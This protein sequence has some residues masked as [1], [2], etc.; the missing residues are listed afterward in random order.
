MDL[1]S[2][3]FNL[4]IKPFENFVETGAKAVAQGISGPF[5]MA[6]GIYVLFMGWRFISGQVEEPILDTVKRFLKIVI[7]AGVAIQLT[8]YNVFFR[9]FFL[10]GPEE[11]ARWL[12]PSATG[13]TTQLNIL[14]SVFTEMWV[15][16]DAFWKQG[17][18]FDGNP[19]MYAVAVC[20]YGCAIVVST[21]SCVLMLLSKAMLVIMLALGPMFIVCMLFD[22]TKKIFETWIGMLIHYGLLYVF[23]VCINFFV[24]NT[25]K[26]VLASA[27]AE[28]AEATEVLTA[29]PVFVLSIFGVYF[30]SKASQMASSFVGGVALSDLGVGRGMAGLASRGV[31]SLTGGRSNRV[32]RVKVVDGKGGAGGGSSAEP[33]RVPR[34]QAQRY[35]KKPA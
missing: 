28:T 9:D 22:A 23:V 20:V 29:A 2:R 6:C 4:F 14:D 16:G 33:K 21:I 3:I 5:Y 7:V 12:A 11:V 13:S 27:S 19:G 10:E 18:F 26:V 15:V 25:A 8:Q 30:L 31:H 17:G 35:N 1:F 24:L 34:T 32:Q